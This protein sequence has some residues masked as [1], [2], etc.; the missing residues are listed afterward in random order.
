MKIVWPWWDIRNNLIGIAPCQERNTV[1]SA[2]KVPYLGGCKSTFEFAWYS[3][4]GHFSPFRKHIIT[5]TQ[6]NIHGNFCI[7]SCKRKDGQ[8]IND[9]G[10]I[11]WKHSKIFTGSSIE[12]K[13]KQEMLLSKSS[14]DSGS[15]PI[16]T[17]WVKNFHLNST[18]DKNFILSKAAQLVRLWIMIKTYPPVTCTTGLKYAYKGNM[19]TAVLTYFHTKSALD[20]WISKFLC[21]FFSLSTLFFSMEMIWEFLPRGFVYLYQHWNSKTFKRWGLV[22]F[23]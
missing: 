10:K 4:M 5:V 18:G 12:S 19:E 8:F 21:F 16:A 23:D 2:I 15:L 1:N 20:T 13:K 3:F 11:L 6:G 7:F 9:F 17:L 22:D 14:M